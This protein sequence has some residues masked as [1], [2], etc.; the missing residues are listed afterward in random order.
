M[1]RKFKEYYSKH[2]ICAPEEIGKR[3]F[4]IGTFDKPKIASRHKAFRSEAE[5]N[6]YLKLEAPVY[7]S[8]SAA[9]YEFPQNQPM[10][11]KIGWAQIWFLI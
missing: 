3:E 8:Y 11:K 6:N 2:K 10:E 9:Y 7:I 5:L 1:K 4:G